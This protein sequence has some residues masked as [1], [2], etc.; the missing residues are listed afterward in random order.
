MDWVA[1]GIAIGNRAEATDAALVEWHGIESALLLYES[2]APR[3]SFPCKGEVLQLVVQDGRSVSA[4]LLRQGA[5]FLRAER[6]AGRNVLVACAAGISRSSS[7][8]VAYLVSE[9]LD[10]EEALS[11]VMERRRVA[12]PHPALLQSISDC[13]ELGLKPT[14]IGMAVVRARKAA[15]QGRKETRADEED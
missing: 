13:Y 11:T 8:V 2:E 3:E 4:G 15:R 9:G 7:F 14:E 5:S 12:L 10:L 6:A 1:D